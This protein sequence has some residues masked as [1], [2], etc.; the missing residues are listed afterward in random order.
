V[1]GR[2]P[3]LSACASG[4]RSLSGGAILPGFAAVRLC[5]RLCRA[6]RDAHRHAAF[7]WPA[8]RC[9]RPVRVGAQ[10]APA[11]AV[12]L[13]ARAAYACLWLLSLA[14]LADLHTLCAAVA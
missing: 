7:G 13:A 8:H 4:P 5:A 12:S 11:R 1:Y 2:D 3:V 14:L 9:G 10:W 6:G